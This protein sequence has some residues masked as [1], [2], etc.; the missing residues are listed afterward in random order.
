MSDSNV[1]LLVS[2][3][4]ASLS[5]GDHVV[6]MRAVADKL[7]RIQ[8]LGTRDGATKGTILAAVGMVAVMIST[9]YPKVNDNG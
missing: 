4:A 7:A 3:L 8:L 1:M 5:C 9:A 6:A 2:D